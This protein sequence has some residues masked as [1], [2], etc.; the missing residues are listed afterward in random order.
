MKYAMVFYNTGWVRD[1]LPPDEAQKVLDAFTEVLESPA[2][3]ASVRLQGVGTATTV[4]VENGKTL[5][6]DGP[7]IESKEFLSGVIVLE[8]AN[9]DE[10]L[11]VAEHLQQHRPGGAVEVRPVDE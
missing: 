7:F 8:A 9:L 5:L 2:V 3:R 10:V 4:R 1:L 6:T 11:A